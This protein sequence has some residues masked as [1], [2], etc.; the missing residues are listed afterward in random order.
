[1]TSS[2]SQHGPFSAV[3]DHNQRSVYLMTQRIKRHP[4]LA[5]FDGPDPNATTADRR[6]TTVPTQALYFLNSPFIHEKAEQ[7][8]NR[9]RSASPDVEQQLELAWRLTTGRAP[10]ESE[11]GEATDFL[12]AYRTE[13]IAA[14]QTNAE[15]AALAAY[16]RALF[17]GNEFLHLD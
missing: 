10:T 6:T 1:M 12:A 2:Y 3:Y 11:R 8:A 5:L 13:L 9:L 15:P 16:V 14:G 4:F 7:C 17:G